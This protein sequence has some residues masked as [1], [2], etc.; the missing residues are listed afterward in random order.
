MRFFR[1]LGLFV[2]VSLLLS[3]VP[4][5][6][7]S[8][9]APAVTT[10]TASNISATPVNGQVQVVKAGVAAPVGGT[11]PAP[12]TYTLTIAVSGSGTVSPAPGSY[13]HPSGTVVNLTATPAP[14][15]QF[16]GW[17]GDV[18]DPASPT[19]RVVMNANKS[20]RANFSTGQSAYSLTILVSGQGTV[21]PPPGSHSYP[22][23]TTIEL[24][25][26]AAP[27]WRFATWSGEVANPT[28]SITTLTINRDITVTASFVDASTPA[29]AAP[30]PTP[31]K[32]TVLP[33]PAQPALPT[34]PTATAPPSSG[35]PVWQI[36]L[37][38][39]GVIAVL[40]PILYFVLKRLIT[41]RTYRV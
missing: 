26:T 23:G 15:G 18:A 35:L 37:I 34:P 17:T 39:A 13:S 10:G 7:I 19:T 16:T 11:T 41:V 2:T 29:P 8:A 28:S 21:S 36:V 14:G 9:A 27:G 30:T 31:P 40:A 1:F 22:A 38:V 33:A 20:V 32:G 5:G 3:L 12:A 6:V 4:A 24:K 25:A